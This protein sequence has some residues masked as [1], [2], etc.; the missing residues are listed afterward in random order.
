MSSIQDAGSGTTEIGPPVD[1]PPVLVIIPPLVLLV[2]EALLE[3]EDALL[4]LVLA[5]VVLPV[6]EV[7][8]E[9]VLPELVIGSPLLVEVV[10]L[11]EPVLLGG[12]IP[13]E[14]SP[15]VDVLPPLLPLSPPLDVL[16][17]ELD[18]LDMGTL[19]LLVEPLVEIEPPPVEDV[20]ET[21]SPPLVLDPLVVDPLVLD[22]LVEI[23][24]PLVEEDVALEFVSPPPVEDAVSALGP[25]LAPGDVPLP[26]PDPPPE[27]ALAG[28]GKKLPLSPV[29]RASKRLGSK[30][31]LDAGATSKPTGMKPGKLPTPPPEIGSP[32]AGKGPTSEKSALSNGPPADCAAGVP[33][34]APP[35]LNGRFQKR[36]E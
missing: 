4:A 1:A 18:V 8:L 22:A 3:L 20:L 7:V 16:L 23:A 36:G 5:E 13:P 30:D 11:V 14:L 27:L 28:D 34:N 6:D 12:I 33:G 19:P 29:G 25:P 24:P 9:P 35:G 26:P 17:V 10:V 2:D 15:P 31:P 32:A 21:G